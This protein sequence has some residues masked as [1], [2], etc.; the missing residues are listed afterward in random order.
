MNLID[1]ILDLSKV[2][3]GYLELE[4]VEFDLHDVIDKSAEMMARRAQERRLELSCSVAPD[5]VTDLVGDPNR[6][7]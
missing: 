5:V 7:R 6:L 1:D 3:A 2:E 4:Q